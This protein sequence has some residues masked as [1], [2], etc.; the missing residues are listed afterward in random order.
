MHYVRWS[1]APFWTHRS[2]ILFGCWYP[3]LGQCSFPKPCLNLWLHKHTH[4]FHCLENFK[5]LHFVTMRISTWLRWSILANGSARNLEL[6][7]LFSF[8][9]WGNHSKMLWPTLLFFPSPF[10]IWTVMGQQ[11]SRIF[12]VLSDIQKR[13]NLTLSFLARSNAVKGKRCL[14]IFHWIF[15][16]PIWTPSFWFISQGD[17]EKHSTK[18]QLPFCPAVRNVRTSDSSAP[19][20]ILKRYAVSASSPES[21]A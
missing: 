16:W 7:I 8:Y 19:D 5:V 3:L 11:W 20:T 14:W 1:S 6:M 21:V 10:R 9:G 4:H 15:P 13:K 17:S 12:C 18:F 2:H